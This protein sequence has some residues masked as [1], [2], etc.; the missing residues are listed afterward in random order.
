MLITS[1]KKIV[2][3]FLNAQQKK[4][5]L[6]YLRNFLSPP[7]IY[8]NSVFL[9]ILGLQILRVSLKNF[10]YK[11]KPFK[12]LIKKDDKIY[13]KLNENGIVVIDNFFN[14]EDF[15]FVKKNIYS[16]EN[17]ENDNTI[18]LASENNNS[19]V[20]WVTGKIHKNYEKTEKIYSKIDYNF[21]KYLPYIEKVLKLKI[22][23]DI[24][25]NYQNLSLPE[26]EEDINDSNAYWHHDRMFPCIKAFISLEDCLTLDQGPYN[27]Y[28]KSHKFNFNRVKN[29]YLN[30]VW[31]VKKKKENKKRGMNTIYEK[32]LDYLEGCEKKPVFCKANSLIISNNMGYHKRGRLKAGNSRKFIRVLF[33]DFQLPFYKRAIKNLITKARDKNAIQREIQKKI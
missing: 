28:Y 32:R 21:K 4:N 25:Y 26:N 23:S 24:K 20:V 16:I 29:E 3:F 33:Y 2:N 30:S 17:D 15:K 19:N 22:N 8:I 18:K 6:Q 13:E 31:W 11:L 9:N 1:L 12:S 10:F 27:Y 5:L 14:E 7:S